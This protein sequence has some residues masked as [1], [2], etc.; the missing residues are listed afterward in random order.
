MQAFTAELQL[1]TLFALDRDRRIMSTRE[2]HP[3]PGPQFVLIRGWS[4][5][6]W[7]THRS[8][9]QRLADEIGVLASEEPPIRDIEDAPVN[10]ERYPGLLGGRVDS[11]PAFTF[12]TIIPRSSGVVDVHDVKLLERHFHGWTSN[13]LPAR[14]PILATVENGHAVSVCFC[15]RRTTVAAEAGVETAPD[16]RGQGL[17]RRVTA[18]WASSIRASGRVPLYSTSWT[19][20]ASLAVAREMNLQPVANDWS[21]FG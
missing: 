10:A 3:R 8:M 1:H 18:A 20:T 15:A 4:D 12:P 11:G 17:A 5:C 9:P 21:I 7:S 13:E 16:F 14:S 19:S 2:P 6:A